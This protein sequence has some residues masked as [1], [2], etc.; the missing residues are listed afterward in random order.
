MIQE[1]EG[2][3]PPQS[4]PVQRPMPNP[5]RQRI[6]DRE[7]LKQALQADDDFDGEFEENEKMK[8]RPDGSIEVE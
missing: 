2:T 7:E 8:L 6:F 1:I 4:H 5:K 3:S